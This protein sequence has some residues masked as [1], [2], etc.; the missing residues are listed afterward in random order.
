MRTTFLY[1]SLLLYVVAALIWWFI[2]LEKQNHLLA[3]KD[4]A[5]LQGKKAY[6][7][8]TDYQEQLRQIERRRTKNTT[9]Y[10]SEGITFLALIGISAVWVYR[11]VRRRI[12]LQEQQEA[13]MMAVTHELKT[14]IAVAKLNLET[15]QRYS[16]DEEKQKRLVKTTLE[17]NARLNFLTNNILV[18]SQLAGKRFRFD[19][20]ELDLSPLLQDC[21]RDF[22]KRYPDRLIKA[23]T[24]EETIL[25]GD[26]LLLQ[27]LVNNLLENA[28][29]YSP[30]G[31]PI[32]LRLTEENGNNRLEVIDQGPGI[33]PGEQKR[34]FERFY[35]IESEATRKTQGTGLG[36]YLC[37]KIALAHRATI[38]VSAHTPQGSNF[39]VVFRS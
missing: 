14:P 11:S 38:S 9:K 27:I 6:I 23:S 30:P 32:E 36:L 8:A 7:T 15:L 4:L 10:I 20:V 33:P 12:R 39:A 17:E 24:P 28:H 31:T 22:Q 1:W 5:S 29:K 26:P 16:L 35:R 21:L 19:P 2:S 13:F 34:I 25:N 18:A 37:K 3:E